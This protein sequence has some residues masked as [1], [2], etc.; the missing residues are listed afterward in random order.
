MIS[1][2]DCDKSNAMMALVVSLEQIE[3]WFLYM[4]IDVNAEKGVA[5]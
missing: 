5:V 1:F 4:Y 2:R 3:F